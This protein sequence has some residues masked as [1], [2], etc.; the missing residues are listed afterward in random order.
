M[1][2]LLIYSFGKRS[3][4]FFIAPN[5]SPEC[6]GTGSECYY[7]AY[8]NVGKPVVGVGVN[9]SSKTRNIQG[10]VAEELA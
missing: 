7:Q 10:W 5:E 4:Y 6:L 2:C 3:S 8:W 9:F 1:N